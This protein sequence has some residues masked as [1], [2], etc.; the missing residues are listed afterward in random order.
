MVESVPPEK[1]N[2]YRLRLMNDEGEN[3]EGKKK[4]TEETDF[5][6]YIATK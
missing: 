3:E 6:E 5:N 4:G 2:Q 1:V